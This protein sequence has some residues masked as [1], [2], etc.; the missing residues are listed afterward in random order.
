MFDRKDLEMLAAY[1]GEHPV[2][3]LYMHLDPR[4]RVTPEAYRAQL[5]GLLKQIH[6]QAPAEDIAA[7]VDYFEKEFDWSGRSV[8]LFSS[9]GS[10]LWQVDQFEMPL[11]SYIHIGRK[12]FITPLA[13]LLDTYGSY[14]V[15]LV[16]QQAIR[17]LYFHLGELVAQ[18]YAEGEDVK[19]LKSGGGVGGAGGAA[20]RGG[21]DLSAHIRETVRGNLKAFAE[22]LVTFCTRHNAEHLLL[23]GSEPTVSQFKGTLSQSWQDRLG[24]IFAVSIQASDTEV[25]ESSLA[26]MRANQK[27]YE[28]KLVEQIRTLDAKNANGVVGLEKTLQAIH[29]GRV[30]TLALV[31][32]FHVS[33]HRCASCGYATAEEVK[34]CP[35]CN[36]ALMDTSDIAEQAIRQV[37]EHGGE[38]KF[39]DIDSPMISLGGIGAFLRY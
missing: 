28:E 3:S 35:Y 31:E 26:V 25:L 9:Q 13:D 23:G 17:M 6:E 19:R 1:R 38:V 32:G 16:T 36:E 39:L 21:T 8:V 33:G 14:S 20:R 2:V 7:I 18:E 10:G 22:V 24:G 34:K 12:P 29:A 27:V 4:L 11:R 5:K 37:V 30:Q 15:A